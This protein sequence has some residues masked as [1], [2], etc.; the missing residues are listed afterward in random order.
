M[1]HLNIISGFTFVRESIRCFYSTFLM[2]KPKIILLIL[3]LWPLTFLSNAQNDGGDDFTIQWKLPKSISNENGNPT[4]SLFFEGAKEY[5]PK[6]SLPLFPIKNHNSHNIRLLH[7]QFL[8]LSALESVL[9]A[10]LNTDN[11]KEI[12][13]L[14][15]GKNLYL[16]P[17][18]FNEAIQQ[19]EKLTSFTLRS[20]KPPGDLTFNTVSRKSDTNT[21][22]L[23]EG[24]WY[25]IGVTS[26]GI[27][28]IDANLLESAGI[29]VNTIDPTTIRI[30]GNGGK[31]LAQANDEFREFDLIENDIQVIGEEDGRIDADDYILFYAQGPNTNYFDSDIGQFYYE[32]NLYSDTSFYFINF[33]MEKGNR[34]SEQQD[35]G[36]S[37]PKVTF[38]DDNISYEVE[39]N[40]LIGSGRKWYGEPFVSS[41]KDFVFSLPG[42][43]PN[44]AASVEVGTMSFRSYDNNSTFN[45]KVDGTS[46]G[47]QLFIGVTSYQYGIQGIDNSD[48]F[49]FNSNI[50]NDSDLTVSLTFNQSANVESRGYL[51]Y[52]SVSVKRNLNLYGAQTFFRSS[53]SLNQNFSSFEIGQT[54]S[55][56]TVWDITNPH[57]PLRQI[58]HDVAD[59]KIGFGANSDQLKEYVIFNENI[60]S[61]FLINQIPNQ[62]LKGIQVP[63]MV[64]VTASAFIGEANRLADF[65]ESNDQLDI[66]VIDVNQ[67]FNEFGSGSPDVT[68][69]RD[70]MKFLYEKGGSD[71]L[72]YLLL[73]GDCSYDYKGILGNKSSWV[74][75]YQSRN[76]LWPTRTYSSDDYFGFLEEDEGEWIENS[77]GDHSLD[78]GIGRLPVN[79][80][81]EA[82]QVVDKIIRY[83]TDQNGLG[84]WR[85]EVYFI[86]DD[87]DGDSFKH[88]LDA[89]SLTSQIESDYEQFNVNKLYLDAFEQEVIP[90]GEI[91]PDFNEQ[92][93][94]AIDKG[95]LILN[96]TGHGA[97]DRLA[98]ETI[99]TSDIAKE[100]DNLYNLPLFVTAT[101]EFGRFDD[102]QFRSG[103]EEL[104]LNTKGGA[105]ALLTTTRPVFSDSNLELNKAFYDE[106]FVQ[107]NGIYPRL[108]DIMRFTKNNSLDGFK[109]R[110]FSLL[111]DPSMR[112]N[113]PKNQVVIDQINE[114]NVMDGLDT[115]SALNK[116]TIRG[117]VMNPANTLIN[118]YEGV[119]NAIVYDKKSIRRTLES[120][121][122]TYD[123]DTQDNVIFKGKAKITQGKYE[124]SFVVPKNISYVA[125]N[126]KISL[127]AQRASGL[128]DA[129]GANQQII[130]GGSSENSITED[131]IPPTIKLYMEDTNFVAGS[132]VNSNTM[133]LAHLTDESGINISNNGIG[134]NISASLDGLKVYN[135]NEFY[136]NDIDSFQSGWLSFPINNLSEGE[137]TLTLRASDSFNNISEASINFKVNDENEIIFEQ[138]YNRP[139]PVL[140]NTSFYIEHNRAGDDLNVTIDVFSIKGE[141][142]TSM[143]YYYE[144]SPRTIVDIEWDARGFRGKLLD[145]GIY[146]YKV[147]VNSLKDG[148]KNQQFEKLVIIK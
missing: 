147:A 88:F 44:T 148:A 40:N 103:A 62:N 16:I 51:D 66:E 34:I 96:Y 89:E 97:E 110:N 137:H 114:I 37:F 52:L 64:I 127:Y 56:S 98:E 11:F 135:L 14:S 94:L 49:N 146:I 81:T 4:L 65:R 58:T 24:T 5:D 112:L 83:A 10:R 108:G 106:V 50:I 68:A 43:V 26:T 25:K 91:A 41:S 63:D 84:N 57:A 30:F 8:S 72:K 55:T 70:Y 38:Y 123:F 6:S 99:F 78:I 31:M 42:I 67:L 19:W 117:S 20:S 111:G 87:S 128:D 1:E 80:P 140:T 27:Y 46:I 105:I 33:N 95:A 113:Y 124:F 102:P 136:E 35:L 60:N 125:E 120:E 7:Q 93:Q 129:N 54:T 92:I 76:S 79:S 90:N 143:N 69:I 39:Q 86:A 109:N 77:S 145:N 32:K 116:V 59:G 115:L 122:L 100:L 17:L 2:G 119:V 118:D 107:S 9:V 144:D 53:E 18:R 131:N 12:R 45:I 139:N 29:A 28:K 61:P 101:C 36:N 48:V 85:N 142:V 141:K 134:H 130:I 74:P 47:E 23:S 15:L 133:L 82:R 73:F 104:L 22:V 71:K 13:F 3:S 21:S 121:G 75:T 126:G 132:Y 138:I